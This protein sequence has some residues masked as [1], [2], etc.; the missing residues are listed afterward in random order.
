M[1]RHERAGQ[2]AQQQDLIDIPNL[3]ASYYVREPNPRK[4]S[5][6]VR[7]GTS[8]HRG[9]SLKN[10]FNEAHVL[11]M[12]QAICGYREEQGITGPLLLGRDTHAL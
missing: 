9:T 1:S 7:F 12:S 3:V 11:A 5:Q 6:Q 2:P 10:T 4:V 8:G